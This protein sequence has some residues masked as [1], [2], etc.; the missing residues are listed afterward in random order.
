MHELSSANN[1]NQHDKEHNENG[2]RVCPVAVDGARGRFSGLVVLT[3]ANST[4]LHHC[5]VESCTFNM[6]NHHVWGHMTSS[7]SVKR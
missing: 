4:V 2:R 6:L 1:Y 3:F 5:G 7:G